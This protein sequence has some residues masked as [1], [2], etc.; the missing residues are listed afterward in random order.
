MNEHIAGLVPRISGE[1]RLLSSAPTAAA[2]VVQRVSVPCSEADSCRVS[3]R[4][5]LPA[6]APLRE[7]YRPPPRLFP[8]LQFHPV[9][10]KPQA[11]YTGGEA[12][13]PPSQTSL[14]HTADVGI[15]PEAPHRLPRAARACSSQAAATGSKPSRRLYS[16]SVSSATAGSMPSPSIFPLRNSLS[17]ALTRRST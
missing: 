7:R 1:S 2:I 8:Q 11:R 5:S 3:I 12:R 13:E 4:V 14:S 16:R 15:G 9:T 10:A 17:W 6:F